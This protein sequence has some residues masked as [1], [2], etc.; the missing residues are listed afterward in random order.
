[1]GLKIIRETEV[2]DG[3]AKLRDARI[4]R[5]DT[6]VAD[7]AYCGIDFLEVVPARGGSILDASCVVCGFIEELPY[8]AVSA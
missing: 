8:I 4:G 3:F 6:R 5:A 1:M 2:A 7:F